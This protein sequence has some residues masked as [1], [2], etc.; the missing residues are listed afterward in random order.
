[1]NHRWCRELQVQPGKEAQLFSGL[2]RCVLDLFADEPVLL[3][4]QHAGAAVVLTGEQ[5]AQLVAALQGLDFA[6]LPG[7]LQILQ[8]IPEARLPKLTALLQDLQQHTA[9]QAAHQAATS[10]CRKLLC[11]GVAPGSQG[12]GT[13]G[14][15]LAAAAAA[16]TEARV[17]LY[18]DAADE[19]AVG[20]L[21]RRGFKVVGSSTANCTQL[22]LTPL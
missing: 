5:E 8:A 2:A 6:I 14:E 12:R 3:S 7:T 22:V 17:P 10:G 19:V 15:L 11:M 13:G 20:M 1:M 18:A 16:A 21:Q 9:A 4:S